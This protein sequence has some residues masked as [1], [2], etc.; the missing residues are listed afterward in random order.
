MTYTFGSLFAGVGGIDRGME[1]AGW[2]C[3]WQV[4]ND[5]YCTRVLE[6]HWPD[7]KRYGDIR[8]LDPHELERVDCI[9]GGFPCQPVS[10]AGRRKGQKDERWLW[11]EF[12]RVISGLRPRYVLVENVPGLLNGRE[13]FGRVLEDLAESGYD[14]EWACIPAAA[15]GAPHLRYRLFVVAYSHVP[16]LQRDVSEEPRP[17]TDL[18][19]RSPD[20]R[21]PDLADAESNGW[22]QG[23]AREAEQFRIFGGG[24]FE[25]DSYWEVEP[26]VGR[27]VDGVPAR[28]DRLRVLGNAV[29]PQVARWLGL[30][31]RR[32]HESTL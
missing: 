3:R 9:V 15:V 25:R 5:P 23:R 30:Q 12:Y 29:V 26:D 10:W 31:I 6:K 32:Y 27:V 17:E 19:R 22:E 16:R 7:V 28:V 18:R 1:L 8:T 21:T 14:G 20:T 4:E 24:S 2:E 11:P 13:N